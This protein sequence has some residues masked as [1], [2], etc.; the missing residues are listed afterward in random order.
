MAVKTSFEPKDARVS[1]DRK[2]YS[3]DIPRKRVTGTQALVEFLNTTSP[4]EFKKTVP[5]KRSSS[6][7]FFKRG[8]INSNKAK[9]A[10]IARTSSSTPTATTTPTTIHRKNYIEII[11]NPFTFNRSKEASTVTTNTATPSSTVSIRSTRSRKNSHI[12]MLGS[13]LDSTLSKSAA[14]S[15]YSINNAAKRANH[16]PLLPMRKS[17]NGPLTV[18]QAVTAGTNTSEGLTATSKAASHRRQ[19]PSLRIASTIQQDDRY[20]HSILSTPRS[21]FNN[22]EEDDLIQ[23]G[24]KQRLIHYQSLLQEKPSDTVSKRL[25]Q[26]HM[27][28]LQVTSSM[29]IDEQ[30]ED[31]G[32]KT[33]SKKK[34]T[35]C[36]H[37]QV[38]TMDPYPNDNINAGINQVKDQ[39]IEEKGENTARGVGGENENIDKLRQRLEKVEKELKQEKLVSSR[40]QAALEETRDQCEVLSGLAYK[41]LRE[42]W[43]EKTRWEHACIETKE[44]CWHDHQQQILGH[45]D[46]VSNSSNTSSDNNSYYRGGSGNGTLMDFIIDEDIEIQSGEDDGEEE[47]LI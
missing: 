40:L 42:V 11:A 20:I 46:G 21:S 6:A 25:A 18:T 33:R 28:A 3:N 15:I 5:T 9:M 35:N 39:Q 26:E 34:R 12:A 41:K 2:Y 36:R 1:F 27:A 45:L 17:N 14:T 47:D 44:R 10:P 19:I 7:L 13:E 22:N 32:D 43:E 8:I 24:L 16:K 29:M 23:E 37:I 30:E 31:G 4:E 38:Q